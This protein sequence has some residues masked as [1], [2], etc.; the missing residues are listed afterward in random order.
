MTAVQREGRPWNGVP[1]GQGSGAEQGE[2]EAEGAWEGQVKLLLEKDATERKEGKQLEN[3]TGE[4]KDGKDISPPAHP[5][6]VRK[7]SSS[8]SA[9]HLF[10]SRP[11]GGA[12]TVASHTDCPL[13]CPT[14]SRQTNRHIHTEPWTSKSTNQQGQVNLPAA[15]LGPFPLINMDM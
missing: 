12:E 10:L 6:R 9:K 5:A 15:N 13:L 3:G 14:S 8:L 4:R 2:S 1:W 7:D 11:A